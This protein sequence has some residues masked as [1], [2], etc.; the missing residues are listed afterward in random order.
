MSE[1]SVSILFGNCDS[2]CWQARQFSAALLG[3]RRSLC[4]CG[5]PSAKTVLCENG[6][7]IEVQ[8]QVI[9]VSQVPGATQ[10]AFTAHYLSHVS[11]CFFGFFYLPCAI[12]LT[13]ILCKVPICGAWH[14]YSLQ[15][16]QTPRLGIIAGSGCAAAILVLAAFKAFQQLFL[17][18][19]AR[20]IRALYLA[21]LGLDIDDEWGD[22]EASSSIPIATSIADARSA[23]G[24]SDDIEQPLLQAESRPSAPDQEQEAVGVPLQQLSRSAGEG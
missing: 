6:L 17:M 1:T 23:T 19:P 15:Q 18:R 13:L 5:H 8:G 24:P 7:P 4:S 12:A 10:R 16:C 2:F 20:H 22:V 14:S 11:W 21:H 9:D 3:P